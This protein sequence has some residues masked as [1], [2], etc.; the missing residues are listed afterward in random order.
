[1]LN[2]ILR[3][4][5]RYDLASDENFYKWGGG[6]PNQKGFWSAHLGAVVTSML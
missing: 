2:L 6:S 4:E 5:F 1:M 3:P